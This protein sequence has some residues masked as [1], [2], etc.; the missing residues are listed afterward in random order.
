MTGDTTISRRAFLKKA[1]GVGATAVTGACLSS[2]ALEPTFASDVQS[3]KA[4]GMLIDVT[5][6]SGCN[7]CALACKEANDRPDPTKEPTHLS[8]DAYS[9]VDAKAAGRIEPVYAKR[10]CMHCVHPACVSACTVGAMRKTPEGPV[11]YDS[12]KC[13][14]CRYCQYAC[15]FGVPTF[16]WDN[17]L[18]LIHK[19]Q[20]CISRLEEGS[21][22][23][24][25]DACPAG[26][27]RFGRRTDLLAQAHA[28]IV[29]NPGR[30]V[31]HVYGETEAGG[32]SVLYLSGVPFSA[33]GL[34]TLGDQPI[35][36]YA[37]AV[38]KRTPVIAVSVASLATG[39][40]W[41]LK[42]RE[43]QPSEA[44]VDLPQEGPHGR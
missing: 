8:C 42:R 9:F 37:E 31:D 21:L 44:R 5:R 10:Q 16:D 27:L 34:P 26:A 33:L 19:C 18:G 32:T 25:V 4:W 39:L 7:S 41:L 28:Q 2:I 23:A 38:M 15:P 30:Y 22:P 20:M 11:V 13:I 6:C 17:P 14:G 40:Y 36:E 43:F 35:P 3:D 29:S 1:A 12:S 24:C